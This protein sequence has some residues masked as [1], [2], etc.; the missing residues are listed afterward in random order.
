MEKDKIY[1]TDQL[2]FEN[3]EKLGEG[4]FGAVFKCLFH[5][6]DSAY[7]KVKIIYDKN[8]NGKVKV[9]VANE[10]GYEREKEFENDK[11]RAIWETTQEYEIQK[12][13][14]TKPIKGGKMVN[15]E[16]LYEEGDECLFLRPSSYFFVE[17]QSDQS[18]FMII[19]SPKARSDLN[20]IKKKGKLDEENIRNIIQQIYRATQYLYMVRKIRHQDLKPSNILLDFDEQNGKIKNIKEFILKYLI[21]YIYF[22]YIYFII[23][24]N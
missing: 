12:I 1:G 2:W 4:G 8:K 17:D 21:N 23:L 24:F 20:I 18:L 3:G 11:E 7:K 5:G 13:V 19:V 15:N 6:K 9:K 16:K 22:N 14:S 10:Y